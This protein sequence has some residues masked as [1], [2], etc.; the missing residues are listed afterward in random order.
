MDT[1]TKHLN[2]RNKFNS[3]I[4][5]FANVDLGLQVN[6]DAL[7]NR[8]IRIVQGEPIDPKYWDTKFVAPKGKDFK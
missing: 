8:I 3:A 1:Q 7:I 5:D 6:R 2:V 4:K